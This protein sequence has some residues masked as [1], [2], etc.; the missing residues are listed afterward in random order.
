MDGLR[1][2]GWINQAPDAA[3]TVVEQS[4]RDGVRIN[5]AN[6]AMPA[7]LLIVCAHRAGCGRLLSIGR[8]RHEGK[9]K[10]V[11]LNVMSGRVAA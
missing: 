10:T 9:W 3:T 2:D 6:T 4:I 7:C 8:L 1:A 5:Q 11:N